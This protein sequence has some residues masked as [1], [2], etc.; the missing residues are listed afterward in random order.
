[1]RHGALHDDPS[2][3]HL[4]RGPCRL[5]EDRVGALR[6]RVRRGGRRGAAVAALQGGE[7]DVT[8]PIGLSKLEVVVT[9]PCTVSLH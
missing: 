8:V 6:V 1:M 7:G 4:C 5:V 2:R 3:R 9:D